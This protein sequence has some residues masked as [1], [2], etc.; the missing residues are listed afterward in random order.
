MRNRRLQVLITLNELADVAAE[1]LRD[2][3]RIT[4]LVR[5]IHIKDRAY[6][7]VARR[8]ASAIMSEKGMSAYEHDLAMRA[9]ESIT[10]TIRKLLIL[11]GIDENDLK[12]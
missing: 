11:F 12:D 3:P 1:G 7:S 9:H 6:L 5:Q 2:D 4:V 10:S 8:M